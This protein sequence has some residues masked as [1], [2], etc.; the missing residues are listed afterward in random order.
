M[1]SGGF[2]SLSMFFYKNLDIGNDGVCDVWQLESPAMV[3]HFRGDPHVH[4][5]VNIR[6]KA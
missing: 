6:A 3:W 2:E 4:K 1:A 5:S